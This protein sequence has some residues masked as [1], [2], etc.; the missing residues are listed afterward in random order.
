M[1][2]TCFAIGLALIAAGGFLL[3]DFGSGKKK[4]KIDA[5]EF[6]NVS[7]IKDG[8][9]ESKDGMVY[10]FV[11]L[12]PIT[13]ELYS[14][15]ELLDF[16]DKLSSEMSGER[17]PFKLCSV[18]QSVDVKPQ[19][20]RLNSLRKGTANEAKKY[21]LARSMEYLGE[22]AT[23]NGSAESMYFIAIWETA[24]DAGRRELKR[25]AE[26]FVNFF[27]N[28]G[29]S[30]RRMEDEEIAQEL[31]C[32]ASPSLMVLDIDDMEDQRQTAMIGAMMKEG[33]SGS[34]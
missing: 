1:V 6:V 21:F 25:R 29:L 27:D 5:N 14:E 15:K 16:A 13:L 33:G 34:A 28:A 10:A 19:M 11:R 24:N 26:N 18:P 22:I 32:Y 9:I 8:M 17:K 7:D 4:A 20:A 3:F 30:A 2:F 31:R 23:S 12:S